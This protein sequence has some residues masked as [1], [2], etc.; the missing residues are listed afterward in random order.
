[1]YFSPCVFSI[2][3]E[4]VQILMNATFCSLTGSSLF[5]KNF[6]YGA[7]VNFL[8]VKSFQ[9]CVI[10]YRLNRQTHVWVTCN[11]F[12]GQCILSRKIFYLINALHATFCELQYCVA[13]HQNLYCLFIFMIKIRPKLYTSLVGYA[14]HH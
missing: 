9:S 10:H 1:M 8:N 13:S 12:H 2:S 14:E 6:V 7:T 11:N 4:T 3:Y 5:A